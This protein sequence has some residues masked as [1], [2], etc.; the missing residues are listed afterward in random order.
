MKIER[1][2]DYRFSP[3][4]SRSL[5]VQN[6]HDY[7]P[8]QRKPENFRPFC[9]EKKS[10]KIEIQKL[11]EQGPPLYKQRNYRPLA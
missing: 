2:S 7:I 8:K 10:K 3:A 4:I 6:T 9:D 5:S 11:A 1:C